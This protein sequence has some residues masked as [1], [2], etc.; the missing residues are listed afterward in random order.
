[1]LCVK[2]SSPVCLKYI[3][4]VLPCISNEVGY[5]RMSDIIIVVYWELM[6][7]NRVVY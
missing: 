5:E 2:W 4:W 6:A 3:L 1:M 7:L